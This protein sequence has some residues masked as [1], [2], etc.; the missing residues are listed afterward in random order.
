MT[1]RDLA[2]Q[3]SQSAVG[4]GVAGLLAGILWLIR[5]VFTNQKQIELM[6]HDQA[7]RDEEHKRDREDRVSER[8]EYKADFAE[9]KTGLRDQAQDIKN[10]LQR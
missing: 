9:I 4:W 3:A 2:D 7:S 6:Q 1:F 8:A 5:R 10:L